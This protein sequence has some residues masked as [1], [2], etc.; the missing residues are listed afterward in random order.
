MDKQY[1]KRQL[2]TFALSMFRKD[3]FGIYHGSLSAKL[4]T[5]L[6]TINTKNAIFDSISEQSLIDLFYN[7]DYRWKEASID[8]SIH[9]GI[10]R[11][12][13]DAK[14]ITFTMPPLYHRVFAESLHHHSQRLFR[15]QRIW[16]NHHL[17]SQKV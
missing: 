13:S 3:F 1:V 4:D 8:A 14:F 5:N 2:A 12:I 15:I 6:F 11:Q 9:Q 7:K 10:Y 17:R 16:K